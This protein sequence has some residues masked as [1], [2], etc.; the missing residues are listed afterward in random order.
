MANRVMISSVIGSTAIAALISVT[1]QAQSVTDAQL[2]ACAKIE[3]PLQRLVCFDQ[4]SAGEMPVVNQQRSSVEDDFGSESLR[5]NDSNAD[6]IYVEIVAKRKDPQGYWIIDLS[7]GQRWRQTES[8]TFQ[9]SDSAEYYI[10]RGILN[11][12]FLGRTDL[13]RRLRVIRVD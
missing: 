12:Y 9:F 4:L 13:N 5:S 3:N 7:N 11:S 1:V 6:K 8:A 2:S 10:E